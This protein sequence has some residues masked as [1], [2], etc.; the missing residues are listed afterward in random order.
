MARLATDGATVDLARTPLAGV[1]TPSELAV[2]LE[3]APLAGMVTLKGDLGSP[4]LAAAVRN[5]TGLDLPAVR[6]AAMSD[7]HTVLWMAPDELLLFTDYAGADALAERLSASLGDAPH[8]AEVVSDARARFRLTGPGAR[9]V[10][11]KGAP[12]DLHPD[13]F[14]LGDVRRTRLAQVA[15]GF[16]QSADDPESFDLVCFRSVAL[17][18]WRWLQASSERGSLPGAL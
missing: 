9:E 12:V 5:A 13:A 17:Y 6:K 8:L 1:A 4:E 14:G 18:V 15:V 11:A 2:R 16:W 10:I 3:E 7:A